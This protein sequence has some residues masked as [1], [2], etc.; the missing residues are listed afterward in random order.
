MDY[1]YDE[2]STTMVVELEI[3]EENE[4]EKSNAIEKNMLDEFALGRL[5]KLPSP[6]VT[7]SIIGTNSMCLDQM[8]LLEK[9]DIKRLKDNPQDDQDCYARQH[10]HCSML[11]TSPGKQN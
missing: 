4:E 9:N 2:N 6:R 5:R 8:M 7:K 3:A 10:M 1:D 11:L